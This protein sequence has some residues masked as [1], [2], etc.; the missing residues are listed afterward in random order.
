M[1]Q[2]HQGAASLRAF[3]EA[4]EIAFRAGEEEQRLFGLDGSASVKENMLTLSV[5]N[6]HVD[7]PVEATIELR[8]GRGLRS[9]ATVL[10]HTDIHAHNTFDAP[11]AL[12]PQTTW[13]DLSGSEWRHT[14]P[15]ASV[16]VLRVPLG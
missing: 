7:Q 14:F 11:E 4:E 6:P 9:S 10:S 3:F 5:V 1:Y 8:G 15:P 16:T 13:F 12:K 2:F